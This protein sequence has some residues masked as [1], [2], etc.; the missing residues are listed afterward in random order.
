MSNQV[1]T[2]QVKQFSANVMTLVQQKGS[3]LSGSVRNE[4]LKGNEGFYEQI[5]ATVAQKKTGRHMATPRVNSVHARR[6]VTMNDYVWADLIDSADKIRMLIDPTSEYAQAAMWAMGRSM[7]DE[8][9]AAALGTSYTGVDGTTQV[10]LAAENKLCAFDGTTA[11]GVN[12]NVAT[13]VGSKSYFGRNEVDAS[14]TLTF[15]CTQRQ[16]DGLLGDTTAISGDYNSIKALVRG[17]MNS[18]VGFNF[19]RTERLP[20]VATTASD[21]TYNKVNGIVTGSIFRDPITDEALAATTAQDGSL[22]VSAKYIR[23]NIAWANSGMLLAKGMDVKG[24]VTEESTL[25]FSTQV[26]CEMALGATRLEEK[27]VLQVY[28]N[29]GAR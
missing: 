25:N 8:I 18:Y 26:F 10:A 4:S 5:G 11:T 16:L 17:E 12:L 29:E 28:C 27:K 13:L 15:V 22:D 1:T 9:I 24:R 3:V 19:I 21:I 2:A 14:E 7:D 6:R 23:S 20:W